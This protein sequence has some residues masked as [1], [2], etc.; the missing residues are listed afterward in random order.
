M[1]FVDFNYEKALGACLK[2]PRGAV[3]ILMILFGT[4]M[5]TRAALLVAQYEFEDN[6]VQ[7]AD[8]SGNGNNIVSAFGDVGITNAALG[9][10][11][12]ALGS[13]A[14]PPL[15]PGVKCPNSLAGIFAGDFSISLWVNTT[16]SSDVGP[17]TLLRATSAPSST[18]AFTAYIYNSESLS[19]RLLI[20]ITKPN[21][22]TLTDVIY[23]YTAV[24]SGQYAHIVLVR[25][26]A[27]N[28]LDIYINGSLDHREFVD[29]TFGGLA[30]NLLTFGSLPGSYDDVRFYTGTLNSTE[31]L[32]LY[33]NPYVTPLPTDFN[34]ALNTTN[35]PWTNSTDAPWQ[36]ENM[37]TRDGLAAQSASIDQNQTSTLQTT[38]AGPAKVSFSWKLDSLPLP[39]PP[40]TLKAKVDGIEKASISGQTDWTSNSLSM[41]AGTHTVSWVARGSAYPSQVGYLD[42]VTVEALP[43]LFNPALNT[44]GFDWTTS[45]VNG[46]F[47]ETEVSGDFVSAAQSGPIPTADATSTLQAT[48]TGPGVLDYY[49]YIS[50]DS[51]L[52]LLVDDAEYDYWGGYS[53]G[54]QFRESIIPAGK[55]TLKWVSANAGFDSPVDSGN[56]IYLDLVSFNPITAPKSISLSGS[57]M[58]NG[59]FLLSLDNYPGFNFTVLS[60]TN[61]LTP[62]SSWTIQGAM[63]ETSSGHF[64]Y[65]DSSTLTNRQKFYAV[66]WP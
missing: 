23:S 29:A 6:T 26:V 44:T 62:L 9:S 53:Y 48:V 31:V 37:T 24:P 47:V 2:I 30:C 63:T 43:D 32:N 57:A 17:Y 10:S 55:H 13:F 56:L 8:V 22:T 59:N 45:D 36:I 38:I 46:W 61:A 54:F 16:Q 27:N 51:I 12:Y 40:A 28:A 3:V 41:P 50:C 35:L 4:V 58:T 60:S 5:S 65:L 1:E 11:Q 64:E 18:N 20:T 25:S 39:Y 15:L 42:Q 21:G 34:I 19:R 14:N 52:R 7:S 33:N 49:F 66:R